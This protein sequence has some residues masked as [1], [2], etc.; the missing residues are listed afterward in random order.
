MSQDLS[1]WTP[2][3]MPARTPIIG[4]YA[5]LEPLDPARHGTALATALND[6]ALWAYIAYGPFPARSE[7]DAWLAERAT[8]ADPLAF[9]VVVEGKA[10]G[11]LSL[12]EMRPA[13]GVLEVG[14]I[15]FSPGLQR[16]RAATDAIYS[17]ARHVFETGWRRLEWKCNMRNEASK[18]AAQRFGFSF[19]GVFRQHMIVKGHNRDTAWF[20]IL[21]HEWPARRAASECWLAP[22]NFD[23]DGRQITPLCARSPG[24]TQAPIVIA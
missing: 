20:S 24:E 17:V 8:L 15:V 5:R 19:E 14:L 23:G 6:E 12:M 7:M 11:L 9:A 18:R 21:D 16:T 4:R 13:M 2:A 3:T 1:G 22:E 10:L